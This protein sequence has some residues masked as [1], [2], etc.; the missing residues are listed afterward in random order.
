[1]S[2][3]V[4]QPDKAP[5]KIAGMFDA[6]AGRYDLL[7]L[8]LSGGL[9][10]YWRRV[11]IASLKLAGNDRLLDVC[12]GT[13]DVAIGASRHGA[14]RVV[15]VDFAG[16][17][18]THGLQKVRKQGLASRIQLVRG[19]AMRLPVTSAS[20]NAA[21]IAFGIRNVM[22]PDVACRELVR[23]LRPGGRVAIL[24]FGTPTSKLFGPVYHWY[25]RNILPR[26]GRAVSRHDA[27]YTYLP[28]SI[29]AFAYGAEFA[30]L[31]SVA[32]FSQVQARP[33]MFGAV[34]LY[35]GQKDPRS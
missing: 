10:R 26:I 22:Q 18:L 33:L 16:T 21:T 14:S 9:D 19:D 6:I 17:M 12:T 24:E 11:A 2:V 30:K 35:T 32:G 29:G 25:S 8:V 4:Q 15:G 31:L 13:A 3:D 5:A 23:V 20:V 28:E 1:M 34:Y 27:A 7:N